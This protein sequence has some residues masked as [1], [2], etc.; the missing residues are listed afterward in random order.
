MLDQRQVVMRIRQRVAVARES[1]SR[2]PRCRRAAAP[3]S[4]ATPSVAT[5]SARSASARSPITVF[6]GLVKMSSTGAKSSVTPT[7]RNSTASARAN[8]RANSTSP[9][10]PSVAIGGH[11]V[12]PRLNRATRPPSWSTLTHGGRSRGQRRDL[13]RHLGDL[14]G[15]LDVAREVDDAAQRELARQRAQLHREARAGKPGHEQL[16][17]LVAKVN[18]RHEARTWRDRRCRHYNAGDAV[19]NAAIAR[20]LFEIGDLL[21]IRGDN[22]FKIRAYRNAAETVTAEPTAVAALRRGRPSRAAG[23]R[24]R[25]GRAHPRNRRDRRHAVP[26]RAAR[27]LSRDHPRPA[28]AAGGRPQDGQAPVRRAGRHLA[29]HAGTGG[30]RRA[31]ARAQGHGRRRRKRSSCAPSRSAGA[32]PGGTCR[33]TSRASPAR[34]SARSAPAEPGADFVP[35]GSLRR[36]AETCGDL[37]I[38]AVGAT[39]RDHAD[40]HG[41]AAGEPC[42]RAMAT[43]SRVCCSTRACRP[44]SGS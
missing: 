20:L 15:L 33:P 28:P 7:A 36:R 27:R 35:V 5:S 25:P 18:G 22:P 31:R 6:F 41:A 42:P 34:S 38:L 26:D 19:D 32:T 11:S 17:D 40:V 21:E 43:P 29:R 12:N 3:R 2:T 23:D 8:C 10:R 1:V 16:S 14:R 37:D 30:P 9:L 4:A 39:A 13:A 24:A 44:T